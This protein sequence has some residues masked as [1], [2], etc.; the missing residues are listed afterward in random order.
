MWYCVGIIY[1][2]PIG[3]EAFAWKCSAQV[4]LFVP[5]QPPHSGKVGQPLIILSIKVEVELTSLMLLGAF[6]VSEP[7]T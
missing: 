2:K 6:K 3:K 1:D 7:L 5:E 4:I